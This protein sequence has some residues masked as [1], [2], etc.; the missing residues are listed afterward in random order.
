MS[1]PYRLFGVELSPFSVKARSYL[2]YKGIPHEWVVRGPAEQEEFQQYAKLPLVPLLITP[3]KQG[4]QDSTP[5][6]EGLEAENPAPSIHP[7]DPA[8]NFISALLEEYGDEWGNKH[9]F[10][11]RWAYPEDAESAAARIADINV[12]ANDDADARAGMVK[13]I[14]QAL[15]ERMVPRLSFV[16]SNDVTGPQIEASFERLLGYLETHL[17]DRPYVFGG[18]P[19]FGDFGL[20]GQIYNAWTDP[21]PQK[22][23]EANYPNVMAWVHRMLDPKAEGDFENADA[24]LPTLEPILK[25]E[26]AGLFLPWSH[27]NAKALAAGDESF[28]VEL[29]GQTFTQTPQKYHARSLKVLLDRYAAVADKSALDPILER[30]GC[31]QHLQ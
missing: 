2:R 6:I 1:D 18:R 27:A 3:D 25:D 28:D 21:V 22:F 11:Y 19:A 4:K 29:Q 8:L 14:S 31:L 12:P 9:M 20:W 10:H 5:I 7:D 15:V 24:L 13:Q 17:A 26:V 16:G 30:T 23:L